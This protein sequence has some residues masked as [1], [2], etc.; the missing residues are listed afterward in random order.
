MSTHKFGPERPKRLKNGPTMEL[1]HQ[2]KPEYWAQIAQRFF[3]LSNITFQSTNSI[4]LYLNSSSADIYLNQA[5]KSNVV[6]FFENILKIDKNS[7]EMKL[8]LV[9]AQIPVSWFLINDSNN[10]ITISVLNDHTFMTYYFPNG[11]YNVYTFI[12]K[13]IETFGSQWT[14]TYDKLQNKLHF[15]N[16]LGQITFGNNVKESNTLLPIIGFIP[17]QSYTSSANHLTSFYSINFSG[18]TKLNIKSS[19]FTFKNMDSFTSGATS[20]F[21]SI[22]VSANASGIIHYNNLTDY[23]SIFKNYDLNSIDISITDE[24][25]NYIDFNNVDWSMTLQI[26]ITNEIVE[27]IDNLHDIYANQHQEL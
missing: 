23:K 20:T 25:N 27:N 21:C 26:D 5:K 19:T 17:T 24:K 13:W 1:Y 6:F 11:N 16:P 15:S 14:I 2:T 9:N 7:I 12:S 3:S 18:L 4:Q 10:R 22:P 8:S